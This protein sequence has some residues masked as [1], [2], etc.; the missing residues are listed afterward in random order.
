[1]SI[2]DRGPVRQPR[3][4]NQA[5]Q[6]LSELL[7]S[8]PVGDRRY[9]SDRQILEAIIHIARTGLSWPQIPIELGG[10]ATCRIRFRRRHADGALARICHTV[11]PEA[12]TRWQ[13]QLADYTGRPAVDG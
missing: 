13:R 9:R 1:M 10:F 2:G 7:P 8:R 6:I 11:L 4:S 5:W 3:I 12:D